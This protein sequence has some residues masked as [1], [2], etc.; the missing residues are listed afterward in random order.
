MGT[1]SI[2]CCTIRLCRFLDSVSVVEEDAFVD[3]CVENQVN[4]TADL[5]VDVQVHNMHDKRQLVEVHLVLKQGV[6][7]SRHL[8]E[9]FVL[10]ILCHLG[11]LESVLIRHRLQQGQLLFVVRVK[12]AL[13]FVEEGTSLGVKLLEHHVEIETHENGEEN[14]HELAL[15]LVQTLVNEYLQLEVALLVVV[16]V[17]A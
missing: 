5:E 1:S 3:A 17:P 9:E 14:A 11:V 4:F 6:R 8:H 12:V 10:Q 7:V 2:A 15:K 13:I 16:G